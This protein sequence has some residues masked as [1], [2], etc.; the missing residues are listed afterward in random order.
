MKIGT[1]KID[2][3]GR[4]QLPSNFLIANSITKGTPVNIEIVQNN[5]YSCKLTFVTWDYIKDRDVK[6]NK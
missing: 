5:K 3:K 4:L 1:G 2:S 6:E